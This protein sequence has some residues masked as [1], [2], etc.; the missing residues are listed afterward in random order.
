MKTRAI[1]L[2]VLVAA[3]SLAGCLDDGGDDRLWMD[4]GE[5]KVTSRTI[6]QDTYYD[7]TFKVTR[8]TPDERTLNWSRVYM[9]ISIQTGPNEMTKEVYFESMTPNDPSAYDVTDPVSV[10][11]WCIDKGGNNRVSEGD[12]VRI[13]GMDR[14]YEGGSVYLQYGDPSGMGMFDMVWIGGPDLPKSFS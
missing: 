12:K 11:G 6:G 10:E 9:D 8:V 4:L 13:T 3:T 5:P 14:S 2:A 1:L 7:V